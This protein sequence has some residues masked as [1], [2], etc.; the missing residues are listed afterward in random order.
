MKERIRRLKKEEL[1]MS[2][3]VGKILSMFLCVVMLMG[4]VTLGSFE[5]TRAQWPTD[6]TLN[7]PI[8]TASEHQW[9]P[10]IAS[11]G[12]GGAIIT[13]G[14]HREDPSDISNIYAQRISA[15]GIIDWSLDGVS[16]CT[17]EAGQDYPEIVPDGSG[18]AIITWRDQRHGTDNIYAQRVNDQGERQWEWPMGSNEY[19]GVPI[20]TDPHYQWTPTIAPD[21]LGGAFIAWRDGRTGWPDIYAQRV[22]ASGVIQWTADGKAICTGT[23]R[24]DSPK[25][26]ADGS[27]GAIIAWGDF[28]NGQADIYAQKVDASGVLWGANGVPICTAS[29]DQWF[30][31][32][33]SDGL[34]GAIITWCDQRDGTHYI[35]AQ[36]VNDQGERLW[37][38]PKGSNE[39]EGVPIYTGTAHA[40]RCPIVPDSSG[41]AIITWI[42]HRSGND[43]IYAQRVDGSGNVQ[44]TVDGIPI[45]EASIQPDPTIVSDGSGGAIITWHD[46][47]GPDL[48]IYAQRVDASG[49]V[50]WGID[51]VSISTVI[52]PQSKPVIV[53]DNSGGAIIAWEDWR[54]GNY[55]DIYTQNVNSDGSLGLQ[56]MPP[57]AEAGGPYPVDEGGT[58]EV[59]ASGSDPDGDELTFAWDLDNDGTFETP[60]QSV[61]FSAAELDG[62]NSQII[63]VRVTDTGGLSATDE[64]TVNVLNIAPTVGE[65]IAPIDPIQMDT[66]ISVSAD[67]MDPGTAD[68]H[69]AEWSWGDNTVSEGEVDETGG[70]GTVIG[71]HTYTTPGV[72]TVTLTVT[73]ND[74]GEA[75]ITSEYVVIYDLTGAFI[76]GG[77]LI[78]SPAGAYTADPTLTGKAGFGFVSKYKKGATVPGGNTQFRFHAGDI[79]FKSESYDWL[80]VAGHKGMFKGTGTN[81]GEGNYG[82]ILSAIDAEL[83][84]STDVDLFRIKI[85]DINTGIILYDNGLGAAD[86]ADPPTALTHGSIK[87]HK[88]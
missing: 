61:I 66:E 68:T 19:E 21:S 16:I 14:D 25:I 41:G 69:V 29:E 9:Y 27:G 53:A 73:D 32:I 22:D 49:N 3:K 81:N 2:Q 79:N 36:K 43:D 5:T 11:D 26:V 83:T 34:G 80:V 39:Y 77:G 62:P 48:D 15:W 85:W 31:F 30:G 88:G 33:V 46:C 8:C 84:P 56:N 74:G 65:I 58:V 51:G 40:D 64:A 71:S 13:W 86:D 50:Q 63:A 52:R 6:P 78:D 87:I 76:T 1:E 54:N 4:V 60:G 17:A 75:S 45:C 44:W 38:W 57:T 72:Y 10:K 70:S 24:A 28:R 37:E 12:L 59:T 42:D 18:G 55:R 7:L 67:F 82:F 23:F 35:Y 20:C 47:R